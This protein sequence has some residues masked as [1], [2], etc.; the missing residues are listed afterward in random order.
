MKYPVDLSQ[1]PIQEIME[2]YPKLKELTV[3]DIIKLADQRMYKNKSL[4]YTSNGIDRRAHSVAFEVI[5]KTYKKILQIN[6]KE[7]TFS[8]INMSSEDYSPSKGYNERI[9]KWLYDFAFSGQVHPEDLQYYLRKTDIEYL[10]EYFT[11]GNTSLFIKYRRLVEEEFH[12]SFME[13][14]ASKD[15]SY[16]NQSVYLYVK[17]LGLD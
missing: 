9:S 6:L 2:I 10:R 8:I 15:F 11:S 12:N 3:D 16:E 1:L 13:I 4:F 7:D 5:C 14:I 17:D